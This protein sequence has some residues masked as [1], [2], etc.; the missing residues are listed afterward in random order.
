VGGGFVMLLA[1][2]GKCVLANNPI[3]DKASL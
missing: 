2:G 1:K 3:L